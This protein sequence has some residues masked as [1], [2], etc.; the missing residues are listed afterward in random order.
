MSGFPMSW[1]MMTGLTMAPAAHGASIGPGTVTVIGAVGAVIWFGARLT[2]R[3]AVG[4]SVVLG[5]LGILAYAGTKSTLPDV[6]WGDLCF[7]G[8]GLLWGGYPLLI[9][10]WKLDGLKVTAVV[11]VLSMAYLPYY[12]AMHFH[13][14]PGVPWWVVIA[15]ALNQGVLNV[16]VGLWI[17]AWA[18]RVLGASIVGRFP[19]M[20]PVIGTLVAIPVLGELPIALQWLGIAMIVGG[21]A[22][23]SWR[24]PETA[25]PA[26]EPLRGG[27]S[28]TR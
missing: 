12:A 28:T 10:K 5:G 24:R 26:Q 23:A 16:V 7:L 1:L 8:V 19:P 2:L 13:G 4:V 17:W 6:L 22:L 11:S 15:H 20:I 3:L 21:L 9:Q 27:S 25:A 14:F 18:A